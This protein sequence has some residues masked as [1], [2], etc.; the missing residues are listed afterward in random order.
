MSETLQVSATDALKQN[1]LMTHNSNIT[2]PILNI[3]KGM[4]C[5]SGGMENQCLDR[6]EIVEKNKEGGHRLLH[7]RGYLRVGQSKFKGPDGN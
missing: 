2:L 6:V 5:S 3:D 1:L 4:A 7:R